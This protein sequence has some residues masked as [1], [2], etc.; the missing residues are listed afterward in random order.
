[1]QKNDMNA[2]P[3]RK[4]WVGNRYGRLVVVS[5]HGSVPSGSTWLCRCDCG[6][7]KIVAA[8]NLSSGHVQSCGCL[9]KESI[10]KLNKT[11]GRS[12][13]RTYDIWCGMRKRCSDS[14]SNKF[15]LYGG[16]GIRVCQRWNRFEEFFADM[17]EC[18]PR[19]SIDRINS[20]GNYE[21]GNCRWATP[22]QQA[23]NTKT[24]IYLT[25]R[26][27]TLTKA[28]WAERAGIDQRAFH[29]RLHGLGWTPEEAVYGRNK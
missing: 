15:H 14:K 16:R 23:R 27:E 7:E 6:T 2:R 4:Q 24:N 8:N 10:G 13:T 19:M 20:D 1:M 29:K 21:P 22:K 11:H 17:G 5:R 9:S 3:A 18:P 12:G 26:G 25:I 28:E